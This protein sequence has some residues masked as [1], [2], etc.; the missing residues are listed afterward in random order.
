M[1]EDMA[2]QNKGNFAHD[3]HRTPEAGQKG[4][5][6]SQS[7]M[8]NR[9]GSQSSGKTGQQSGGSV[10]HD[11]SR[12]ADAGHKGGEHSGGGKR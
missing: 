8:P 3:R 1:E 2:D 11:P 9:Q 4:G 6:T 7:G 10:A 5:Q 12:A